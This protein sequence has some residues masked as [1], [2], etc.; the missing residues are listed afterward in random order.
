MHVQKKKDKEKPNKKK[1]TLLNTSTSTRL[2]S[3]HLS[4]VSFHVDITRKYH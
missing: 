1:I 3:L 4:P 2:G